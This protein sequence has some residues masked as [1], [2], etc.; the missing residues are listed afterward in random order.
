[1]R[2]ID[3]AKLEVYSLTVD[4]SFI[5]SQDYDFTT[6]I[7]TVSNFFNFIVENVGKEAVVVRRDSI[8]ILIKVIVLLK[9]KDKPYEFRAK[10]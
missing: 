2:F 4:R 6:N 7:P 9:I 3:T 8:L 1:M 5:K 10:R